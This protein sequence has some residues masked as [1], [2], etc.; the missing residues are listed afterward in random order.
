MREAGYFS[1]LVVMPV[2]GVLSAL[3]LVLVQRRSLLRR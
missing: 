3:A 1:V 2:V